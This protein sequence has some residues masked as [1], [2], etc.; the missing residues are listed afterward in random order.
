[1]KLV[2]LQQLAKRAM[3][4]IGGALALVC[5]SPLLLLVAI[6]VRLSLGG[7]IIFRQNR[8]GLHGQL[9]RMFKFRTMTTQSDRHGDLLPDSQ[10]LTCVGRWL[11]KTSLDE[12][13][14]LFNVLRGDM[15]LVGPRPLLERYM[16]YY[17]ASECRRHAVRPGITGWAQIHGRNQA[18]W[19]KRLSDDVWYVDHWSL[20]LDMWILCVTAKQV[21]LRKD[22]LSDPSSAMKD[23]DE[24]R[25]TV[26][27]SD[28]RR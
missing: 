7:P 2:R 17:T 22:V 28:N 19:D 12:L 9:F 18:S 14:E 26:L 25:A 23:L 11:R 24:E 3:D 27:V 21:L 5:L 10:R 15:S 20:F 8:P 4:M 16:P 13:P 6:A 1:M